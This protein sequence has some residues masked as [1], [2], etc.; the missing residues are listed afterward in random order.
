METSKK[1]A[2]RPRSV[3][4][5]GNYLPRKCGIA[6]YTTD[7]SEALAGEIG[8]R[9][10]VVAVAMDDLPEGYPYPDRVRFQVRA[11]RQADYL[12]ATDYINVRQFEIALL[13][14]EFGIFGGK[15]GAYVLFLIKSLR[16]PVITTLH[17]VLQEPTDEQRGVIHSLAEY[18]D[19]LIVLS[20]KAREILCEVYGIPGEKIVHIPHG[21]PDIPFL[22]PDTVKHQFGIEGRK[23][24]LTF[25]LLGPGKGIEVMLRA[26]PDIIEK[27]PDVIYLI[28]GATHPNIKRT[29][30][31]KYRH[32]LQIM[33]SQLGIGDHVLFH[34]QFVSLDMLCR[35]LSAADIYCSPYPGRDQIISGTLAYAMGAGTAIVSTPY[36]YAEEM[37]ADGRGR[38]V[39]FNDSEAFAREITALLHDDEGRAALR[40][41]AYQH[42]R[43]MVWK[44]VARAHIELMQRSLDNR[45]QM[46][47]PLPVEA[48]VPTKPRFPR[49]IEKLPEADLRHLR[50]MTDDTG[51]LQH[52]IHSTPRRCDGYCV[53][54]NAR[55]LIFTSMYHAVS[56]DE[57]IIRLTH[58]YLAFLYDA[59][60]TATGRFRNFLSFDRRWMEDIGSED[61]HGRA[62]W[63]LGETVRY[64]PE[65]AVLNVATEL[66]I[67]GLDATKA[68]TSPRA[69]AFTLIGIHSYMTVYGGDAAARRLRVTLANRIHDQFERNAGEDWPWCEETLTYCNGK[70]PHAMLLSGQW[71]P[72]PKMRENG[73]RSLR[74]LLDQQT[75]PEGHFSILGNQQPF[76]RDGRRSFFDQQPVELLGLIGAC[77]EAYRSTGESEWLDHCER[78][79]R[80]F[81]GDNDINT[82]IYDHKTGGCFDGLQFDGPNLN[83]GAE[84]TLSWLISLMTMYDILSEA[85]L[86]DG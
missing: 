22:Q 14:H 16:M 19:Y 78:C 35:Y 57:S 85:L 76:S 3:I 53:D 66:F 56:K 42:C 81:L 80:W 75:A 64:A 59:F 17:T 37:L 74:W 44:Q 21:I 39:P 69:I 40:S 71:I 41:R 54:D 63:G 79:M 62:L 20:G 83:Q 61:S 38:L 67:A 58:I 9:G 26:L 7:I 33:V 55:A 84:S 43:P 31:D 12:R 13:Q 46:P 72:D 8:S 36:W 48:T 1:S 4:V 15:S 70:L 77:A 50:R 27:H 5:I 32:D 29:D 65:D 18:S 86:D 25:G 34:D 51:L 52:A 10:S 49:L 82:P 30:G 6:T 68:F 2:P 45:L 60:N 47:R 73:I 11:N 28:L 24:I 23:L